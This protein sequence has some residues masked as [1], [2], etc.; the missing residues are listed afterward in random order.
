MTRISL[1]ALALG[2][3]TTAALADPGHLANYGH[4]H[5]HWLGYALLALATAIPAGIVIAQR[6]RKAARA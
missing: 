2:A 5:A 4:G 6:I 3:S 1:I